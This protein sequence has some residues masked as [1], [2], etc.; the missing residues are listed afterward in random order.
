MAHCR[1]INGE[2]L[3]F[4]QDNLCCNL[5]LCTNFKLTLGVYLLKENKLGITK[6]RYNSTVQ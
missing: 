2:S 1:H 4:L 6:V 5:K 3:L